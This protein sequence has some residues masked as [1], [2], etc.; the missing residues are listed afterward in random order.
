MYRITILLFFCGVLSFNHG[1]SQN[2]DDILGYWLSENKD[3]QIE[4]VKNGDKYFGKI[5]WLEEP[6]EEDGSEKRD[7]ENPDEKLRDRKIMGLP[8][9]N[10]FVFDKDDSEWDDGTIYDPE[11]GS[12]YNAYM[13]FKD[14]DK[15]KL[16]L[17]G[18][19]GLSIIGRTSV[20]TRESGKR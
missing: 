15:D 6:Y 18:Y 7:D 10:D 1:L 14:G 11:S 8:L 3:A 20:W 17:R 5:I 4:I 16:N 12:T 9:L 19:I 13:W 2:A